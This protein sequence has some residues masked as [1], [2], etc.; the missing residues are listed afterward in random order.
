MRKIYKREE[1]RKIQKKIKG[2]KGEEVRRR[3]EGL[4]MNSRI[5]NLKHLFS[6]TWY[7]IWFLIHNHSSTKDS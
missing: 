4:H 6:W 1:R 7:N 3:L 2:I 5:E